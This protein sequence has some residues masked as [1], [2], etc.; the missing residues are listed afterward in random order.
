MGS[1]K[2]FEQLNS[3]L[4]NSR[5]EWIG[6]WSEDCNMFVVVECVGIG[7]VLFFQVM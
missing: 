7:V 5:M 6:G 3:W 1:Q 2:D 4:L